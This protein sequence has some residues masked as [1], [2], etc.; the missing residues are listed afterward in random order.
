M[1]E[2]EIKFHSL[3]ETS[4]D[5]I[6]ELDKR[7]DFQYVSPKSKEILGYESKDLIEISIQDIIPPEYVDDYHILFSR[8]HAESSVTI[9]EVFALQRDRVSDYAT[10]LSCLCFLNTAGKCQ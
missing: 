3:V 7:G 10:P 5:M 4:P 6:W 2:S 8:V 1:N 9:F